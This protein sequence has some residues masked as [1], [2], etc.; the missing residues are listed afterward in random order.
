MMLETTGRRPM[1]STTIGT[2]QNKELAVS[3]ALDPPKNRV[4]YLLASGGFPDRTQKGGE[5]EGFDI[6]RVDIPK[7]N[8]MNRT[9]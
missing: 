8:G 5:P 1:T 3:Y 7:F 4:Q 6:Q 2:G 9:I